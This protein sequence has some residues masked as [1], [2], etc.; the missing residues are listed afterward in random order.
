MGSMMECQIVYKYY[1]TFHKHKNT[2]DSNIMPILMYNMPSV[3]LV[4]SNYEYIC[5]P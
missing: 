2:T 4:C 5:H 1:K 3:I